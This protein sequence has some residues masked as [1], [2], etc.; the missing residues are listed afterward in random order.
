MFAAALFVP[1]MAPA[2]V[3][4]NCDSDD[5]DLFRDDD[6]SI[7]LED[8]SIIFTHED[9][10][11][12]VE[13]TEDGKLIVNERRVSL[14]RAERELVED[15]YLTFNAIIDEA[16]SIG[17]QGAKVGVKGA[18]LGLKAALGVLLLLSPDY[19]TDD[20]EEDLEDEGEK[21]DRMAKKI[22]K[23][24]KRLEKRANKLERLHD[25]LRDRVDELD[26]LGWF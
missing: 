17:I 12:T 21:I 7:D 11:E 20:L 19:D 16:K 14:N 22:E 18:A 23:R 8:H 9:S 6:V 10:D 15:Y 5:D 26:D 2:H 1:G 25:E 13:I 4:I 24:A 3:H